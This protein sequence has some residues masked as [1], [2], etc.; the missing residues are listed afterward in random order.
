MEFTP[1]RG[2]AVTSER[3][4][5]EV[6][7]L[8]R[9]MQKCL[10]EVIFLSSWRNLSLTFCYFWAFKF[11]FRRQERHCFFKIGL[12]PLHIGRVFHLHFIDYLFLSFPSILL[13][14]FRVTWRLALNSRAQSSLCVKVCRKIFRCAYLLCL[15]IL[16]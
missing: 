13:P 16:T 9:R 1:G 4:I 12:P 5:T 8:R 15:V 6:N 10:A 2:T 3:L 14:G 11:E 7:H